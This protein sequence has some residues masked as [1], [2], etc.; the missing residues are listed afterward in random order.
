MLRS[1]KEKKKRAKKI[2]KEN[3][4]QKNLLKEIIYAK[5]DNNKKRKQPQNLD[6]NNYYSNKYT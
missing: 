3:D 4:F 6:F 2:N 1:K 5:T